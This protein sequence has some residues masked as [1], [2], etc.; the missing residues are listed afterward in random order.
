MGSGTGHPGGGTYAGGRN[1]PTDI[2]YIGR[3]PVSFFDDLKGLDGGGGRKGNIWAVQG[4]GDFFGELFFLFGV[5]KPTDGLHVVVHDF[6]QY[7]V[8]HQV[9]DPV[10]EFVLGARTGTHGGPFGSFEDAGENIFHFLHFGVAHVVIDLGERGHYIGRFPAPGNDVMDACI[11]LYV[12]PHEVDHIVEGFYAVECGASPLG[13]CRCVGGYAIEAD[14]G[15]HI[16]Q[17]GGGAGAVL[18]RRVPV[19]HGVHLIEQA[20]AH[21]IYFSGAT[22]FSRG[23]VKAYRAGLAAFL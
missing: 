23:A 16:G 17:G 12:F 19:D 20:G 15:R 8:G 9:I 2:A 11:L 6:A 3:A 22:F 4:S 18:A 10:D 5:G 13:G 7:F 21:H 1:D 14:F